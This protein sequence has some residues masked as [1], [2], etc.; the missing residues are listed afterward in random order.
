MDA[1]T[2]I[3]ADRLHRERTAALIREQQ[4]RRSIADR[5]PQLTPERPGAPAH[6]GIGLWLRE[7]FATP[8]RPRY[9]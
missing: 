7:H 3:L 1:T 9:A 2:P 8:Q 4:I 5:G 6:T